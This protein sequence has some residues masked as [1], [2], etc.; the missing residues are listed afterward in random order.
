MPA[1]ILGAVSAGAIVLGLGAVLHR[2]LSAIPQNTLKYGVGLLLGAFGTFWAIEGLGALRD[3]HQS[4]EWPGG[5]W[6]IVGLIGVW[7]LATRL[8]VTVLPRVRR[9][10]P[11]AVRQG[12]TP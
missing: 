7:L 3:G 5:D 12:V 2:P 6:S 8:L 9:A 4:L 1:S 11:P 10:P